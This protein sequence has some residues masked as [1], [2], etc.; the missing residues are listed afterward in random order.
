MFPHCWWYM[1]LYG[2]I[3]HLNNSHSNV[4]VLERHQQLRNVSLVTVTEN[5]D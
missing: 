2:S 3:D 1:S 4:V 5:K